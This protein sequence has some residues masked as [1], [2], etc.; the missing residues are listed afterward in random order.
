SLLVLA[1]TLV[2][3]VASA[4][5]QFRSTTPRGEELQGRAILSKKILALAVGGEQVINNGVLVIGPDGKIEA[6]G[7][8]SEV[9]IPEG[10]E[11]TDVGNRWL[12]PGLIDL[13]SHIAG[14]PF[15]Q[16]NNLNDMV[17]MTNPG[18]RASCVVR[19][20]NQALRRGI[21]GG[22]TSILFIPGSGTNI[23]GQGVLLKT[24]HG[25]YED[26]EIR[27]PGSLKLAQAGNPESWVMGVRRSLM[28]WNTRN[29]F[30]R[31][32][33]Y[34]KRWEAFEKNGAEKPAKDP[35]FEVFRDLYEKKTQVSTHT[36]IYQ[37][38][39]M[40]VSMI[41]VE[42]G[43]PVYIDHGTFDGWRA[44]PQAQENGVLAILGP[45]AISRHYSGFVSTDGQIQ[46]VAAK[47]QEQGHK[48]IG[49][50]TDAP[51]IPQEEF[52][53]QSAMGVRYGFDTSNLEHLLGL[54]IVPAKAAGI[55]HLVGSLEVGKHADV[56]VV[57]GDP[58][59]PRTSVELA[60]IE[61]HLVYD[62]GRDG[63]VW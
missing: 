32:V 38:V 10:Y 1:A 54:T 39:N 61:G 55:D 51:V 19:P 35:Q 24:W 45:R 36:Q 34:A 59:D 16:G 2:P 57:T 40:T 6:C 47:Y 53:L 9:A 50:N 17:Y 28:N 18:L 58:A 43:L 37:V 33:A 60:F 21:A 49:F 22:V 7:P 42:M 41:A 52:H 48:E 44:A 25:D 56:L 26:M 13:H 31:G 62:S 12:S 15:F 46:G 11:V 27:N 8:Q 30:K 14:P 23:G 20:E 4:T 63:R 5:V 29:T 3:S